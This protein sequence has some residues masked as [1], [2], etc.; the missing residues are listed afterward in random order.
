VGTTDFILFLMGSI[1]ENGMPTPMPHEI[2]HT[3]LQHFILRFIK[4]SL[5]CGYH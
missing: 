1:L 3:E 2:L 5:L 4:M